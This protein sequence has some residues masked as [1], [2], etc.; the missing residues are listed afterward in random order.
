M[1]KLLSVPAM[2]LLVLTFGCAVPLAEIKSP[3]PESAPTDAW[4]QIHLTASEDLGCPVEQLSTRTLSSRE[5]SSGGKHSFEVTGCGGT[6]I[7]FLA[8]GTSAW[9]LFSDMDLRRKLKFS[10]ADRCQN[11]SV[12]FIDDTTRGVDACGPKLIYVLSMSGWVANTAIDA[13]G[14]VQ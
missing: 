2:G 1:T 7:F 8:G 5:E 10:Y 12:Q 3:Q 9:L 11:W 4:N 14:K 6:D 13:S